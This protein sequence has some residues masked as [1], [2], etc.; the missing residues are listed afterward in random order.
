MG[1]AKESIDLKRLWRGGGWRER[2]F[3][4]GPVSVLREMEIK[5]EGT[6]C[7]F[8]GQGGPVIVPPDFFSTPAY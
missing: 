5:K 2:E 7:P 4:G 6:L 1:A 8:T 3:G